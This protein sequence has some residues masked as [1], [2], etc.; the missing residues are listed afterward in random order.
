MA[1]V[2]TYASGHIKFVERYRLENLWE[3]RDEGE[4]K[5]KARK[6]N[7][8]AVA[9]SIKKITML[10]SAKVIPIEFFD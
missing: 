10:N 2:A 9:D 1:T 4:N 7:E 5:K 6:G 8:R 3:D